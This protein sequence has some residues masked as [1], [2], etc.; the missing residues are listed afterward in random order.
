MAVK[1]KSKKPKKSNN[2]TSDSLKTAEVSEK[3]EVLNN[4]DVA[5][6]R[7]ILQRIVDI[8]I[9]TS[10]DN[11]NLQ[12][13]PQ[14]YENIGKMVYGL[15]E[16]H[17]ADRV[18]MYKHEFVKGIFRGLGGVIGATVVL[19]ILLLIFSFL[20]EI[21]LLGDVIDLIKSSIPTVSDSL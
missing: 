7:S 8:F 1:N 10:P 12:P 21:P 9:G 16:Y 18:A 4:E 15:A 20:G 5:S 13:K 11:K 6:K 19:S 17:Y 2:I 3:A 14:D